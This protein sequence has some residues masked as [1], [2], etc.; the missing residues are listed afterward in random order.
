MCGTCVCACAC[1]CARACVVCVTL[2]SLPLQPSA[3]GFITSALFVWC[4]HL[5]GWLAVC[6]ETGS[7]SVA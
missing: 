1:V 6:F 3:L 5:S 4:D 7:H 2:G